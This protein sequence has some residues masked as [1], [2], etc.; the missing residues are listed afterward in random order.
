M[1]KELNLENLPT[2][3]YCNE[4]LT[5]FYWY[6]VYSVGKEYFKQLILKLDTSHIYT[7]EVTKEVIDDEAS[8]K[9]KAKYVNR[10]IELDERWKAYRDSH[11]DEFD[12]QSVTDTNDDFTMSKCDFIPNR[13][14]SLQEAVIG[15]AICNERLKSFVKDE[16]PKYTKLISKKEFKEKHNQIREKLREDL[17]IPPDADLKV[18]HV[19][20]GVELKR[21]GKDLKPDT[22]DDD[23]LRDFSEEYLE[24][25]TEN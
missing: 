1:Q 11:L 12:T 17:M 10:L 25:L 24:F 8:D 5:P 9:L 14:F 16:L 19:V 22:S 20:T 21:L 6:R 7:K 13:S 4:K 2:K 15:Y 23:V 3:Y 18:K